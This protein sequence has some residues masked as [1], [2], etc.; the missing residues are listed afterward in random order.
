MI[1]INSLR[2]FI[3]A[4]SSCSI[5]TKNNAKQIPG[6]TSVTIGVKIGGKKDAVI[7]I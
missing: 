3:Y 5:K 6:K 2:T 4:T 1:L 7:V